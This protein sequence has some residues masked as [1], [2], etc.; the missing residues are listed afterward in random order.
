MSERKKIGLA[1]GGGVARGMAHIGVLEVLHEAGVPIDFVAGTSAGS[2]IGAA[3][4][5]GM[6]PEQIRSL[7]QN[8]NWWQL[9]RPVW[10]RRGLVSFAPM[11]RW[12][13]KQYGDLHFKD[14]RLPFTAVAVELE[15]GEPVYLCEGR[16][17]P[18]ICASCAVPGF[19]EPILLGEKVL[20]DGSITDTVPVAVLR[21]MGADF[22]IGV[23]VFIHSMRPRWGALGMG[24]T[25]LEILVRRAGGGASLAD[26]MIAPDLGALTYLRFSR[27]EQMYQRG[28]QAAQHKLPDILRALELIQS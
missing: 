17:A 7:G 24:F 26:C 16:L 25:A 15:T 28:R 21:R 14:L 23:D 10:P 11:E 9:A 6:D 20:A 4:C 27:R 5:A 1:L 19:V 18:A 12:L 2:V 3:Y 8:L 22:V 13:V